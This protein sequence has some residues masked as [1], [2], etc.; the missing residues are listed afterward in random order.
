MLIYNSI[1]DNFYS[2][3]IL[4]NLFYLIDSLSILSNRY[5]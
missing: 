2:I 5:Q 4:I 1:P 3:C